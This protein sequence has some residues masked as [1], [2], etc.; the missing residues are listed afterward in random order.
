MMLPTNDI[1]RTSYRVLSDPPAALDVAV[2]APVYR[3]KPTDN[4]DFA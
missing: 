3:E 4:R 1:F 2:M